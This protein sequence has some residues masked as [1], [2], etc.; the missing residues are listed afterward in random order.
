MA[1]MLSAVTTITSEFDRRL[2]RVSFTTSPF[3]SKPSILASSAEKKTSAGAPSSICRARKLDAPKLN[4]ILS[5]V[6]FS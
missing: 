2:L 6:C 5:P 1:A 3:F 4:T